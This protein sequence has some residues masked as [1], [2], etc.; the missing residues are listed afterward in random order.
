MKMRRIIKKKTM[1]IAVIA[2]IVANLFFSTTPELNKQ[3]QLSLVVLSARADNDTGESDIP[4]P[5]DGI[6]PFRRFPEGW[7]IS[8]ILDYLF[9]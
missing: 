2:I 8:A 9:K 5:D 7:S 4:D 6:I 3:S 1:W